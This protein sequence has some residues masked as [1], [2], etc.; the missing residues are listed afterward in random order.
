MRKLLSIILFT[1]VISGAIGF[2]ACYYLLSANLYNRG[3]SDGYAYI[4]PI[5]DLQRQV[6][7]VK[8]DGWF[9]PCWR[10]S[11][12]QTKYEAAL[13]NKYAKWMF[14]GKL[15]Q[16]DQKMLAKVK[17]MKILEDNKYLEINCSNENIR[18]SICD[19]CPPTPDDGNLH[20]CPG[21]E[22]ADEMEKEK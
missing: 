10:K 12:T 3:W 18:M 8:I 22:L 16:F 20:F 7:C 11:E 17:K 21:H 15:R 14:N 5:E 19:K 6:G 1:A 4:K 2:I 13:G 9:G